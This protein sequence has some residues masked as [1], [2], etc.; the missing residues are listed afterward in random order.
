MPFH[1]KS[2]WIM[3]VALLLGGV[4]YF[5][6]VVSLSGELGGLV[7]PILPLVVLYTVLLVV[8]AVIGHIVVAICAPREANA[9]LDER[10]RRIFDRAG[11]LSGYVF[12][13]GVL[14]SLALYLF[15]YDGN[16]LFY[17]VFGSLMLGQLAEY[18]IQIRLYRA[19]V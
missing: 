16:L 7:P 11:H 2:A 18:V 14:L 17:G 15:T 6:V 19:V 8:V 1:E 9:A 10:E 12:G 4:F 13:A 5:A 3:S